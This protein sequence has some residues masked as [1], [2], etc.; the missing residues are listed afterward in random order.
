[1]QKIEEI[2]ATLWIFWILLYL[3]K[4]KLKLMFKSKTQKDVFQKNIYKFRIKDQ[5]VIKHAMKLKND[6][7]DR[8]TSTRPQID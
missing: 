7:F 1:M 8:I 2:K 4:N 6:I 3:E 5:K